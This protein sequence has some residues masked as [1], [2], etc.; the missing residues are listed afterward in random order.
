MKD[1]FK[2]FTITVAND[3]SRF[4]FCTIFLYLF[5]ELVNTKIMIFQVITV[6]VFFG[7]FVFTIIGAVFAFFEIIRLVKE[8]I[9]KK[10]AAVL[11][12]DELQQ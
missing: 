7:L 1:K 3:V 12:Q 2:R 9:T 5:C 6:I 8:R 11:D 10:A 4:I